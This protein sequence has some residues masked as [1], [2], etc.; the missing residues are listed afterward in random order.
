MEIC[1]LSDTHGFLDPR[2]FEIC[3]DCDEIWHAGDF[4]TMEVIE[5]LMGFKPLR[6]V[7]GNIDDPEIRASMPQDLR[8]SMEGVNVWMTHIAG[9][10]GRYSARVRQSLKLN[11]PQV[12]ICGHT[13]IVGVE[14]DHQHGLKFINPGAAGH[15]GHHQMRTLIKAEFVSGEIKN[16]RLVELGPRG[17][18][19]V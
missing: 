5:Q 16:L 15:A 19:I 12:L 10:P 3:E 17:R 18:R 13:H 2:V 6:G 1:L 9:S 8:F 4:G 11:P 7:H 14:N